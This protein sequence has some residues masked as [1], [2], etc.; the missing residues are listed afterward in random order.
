MISDWE[1]KLLLLTFLGNTQ[2]PLSLG[3]IFDLPTLKLDVINGRSLL[4]IYL[5]VGKYKKITIIS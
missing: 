1:K 4:E 3:V 5:V 2:V